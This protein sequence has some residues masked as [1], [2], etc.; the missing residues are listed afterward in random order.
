MTAEEMVGQLVR[1]HGSITPLHGVYVVAGT[2]EGYAP[3]IGTRL[4]LA[5]PES[6]EH[7]EL[8]N[9]RPE[10]VTVVRAAGVVA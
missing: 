3:G 4:F 7:V 2:H 5:L 8:S 9:V 6:P 1:Y 10:S